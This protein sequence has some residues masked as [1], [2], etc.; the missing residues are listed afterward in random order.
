MRIKTWMAAALAIIVCIGAS[1]DARAAVPSTMTYHG[2]LKDSS[3]ANLDTTVEMTFRIYDARSAGDEVWSETFSTI[4]VNDG[5]FS[6]QLGTRESLVGVFDGQPYWLEVTIDGETLAPRTPIESVPYALRANT[7]EDAETLQGESLT[8]VTDQIPTTAGE[9]AYDNASSG[10]TATDVQAAVDELAALRARI[11]ALESNMQDSSGATINLADLDNRIGQNEGA[12]ATLQNEVGANQNDLASLQN[13][14]GANQSDLASL[15]T[16]VTAAQGDLATLQTD[17]SAARGD[18][19]TLQTDVAAAQGDIANH[20]TEI[21]ALEALTQ[22]MERTTVNGYTAVTFTGVNVHIRNGQGAT[23]SS[24]N[25]LG[26]LVVGY[27]E[28]RTT[29]SDKSGSHNLVVGPEH[30]YSSYGGLVAGTTNT[31]SAKYA[32]VSGGRFNVASGDY[33]AVCGGRSNYASGVNAAVSGGITNQASAQYSAVSAGSNNVASAF[34]S[35]V[36]GGI[37]NEASGDFSA[38]SGGETRSATGEFDWRGGSLW[39]TE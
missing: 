15:Q 5:S 16:D 20:S 25:G 17:V 24:V 38:V 7:A 13:E 34:G 6:A 33:A 11:E 26:N 19:T 12:I 10:L 32:S 37:L 31:T 22:D 4:D 28:A 8:D 21:G 1:T 2:Q 29:N 39:A 36:S 18:I 23:D 3:G 9:L 14:V 27:D 35:S 30:N